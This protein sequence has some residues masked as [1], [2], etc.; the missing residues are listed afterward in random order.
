MGKKSDLLGR[1]RGWVSWGSFT[2][3][4]RHGGGASIG[5]RYLTLPSASRVDTYM[6]AH[7]SVSRLVGRAGR[8]GGR[9]RV[10]LRC[11]LYGYPVLIHPIVY[12]YIIYM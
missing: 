10:V 9:R 12:T 1:W 6:C 2:G 11:S 4:K 7:V 8:A 3:Q 5:K